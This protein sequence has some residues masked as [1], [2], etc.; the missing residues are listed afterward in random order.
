MSELIR[1]ADEMNNEEEQVQERPP[2]VVDNDQKAEWCIEQIKHKR[3]EL[4]MWKA[5]YEKMFDTVRKTIESDIVWFEGNLKGYFLQQVGEGMVRST[6]NQVS[7][8]LPHGKLV[9]KHQEPEYV[10]DDDMIVEWLDKNAPKLVKVKKTP[11]WAGM[12][13]TFGFS[14]DRMVSVDEDGVITEIPGVR[15]IPRDD[16]FK[17]EVK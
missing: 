17:V 16:I 13:K 4:E 12:K 7:Y 6:K 5:H 2:F 9:L 11:D 1:D 10:K 15:A 8:A 14:E 3:E